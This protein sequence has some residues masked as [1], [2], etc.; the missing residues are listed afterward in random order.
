MLYITP[1]KVKI[2]HSGSLPSIIAIITQLVRQPPQ[3]FARVQ[4]RACVAA[5]AQRFGTHHLVSQVTFKVEK[6]YCLWTR[7]LYFH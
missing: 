4:S 3:I 5:L 1:V 2:E 7:E 6:L